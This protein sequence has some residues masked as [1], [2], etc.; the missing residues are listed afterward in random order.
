MANATTRQGGIRFKKSSSDP[1]LRFQLRRLVG[2]FPTE[3]GLITAEM[4]VAGR[5]LI[6]WSPEIERLNDSSGRQVEVF[7][8]QFGDFVL[9]DFSGSERI[10]AHGDRI[11]NADGVCQLNLD[12]LGKTRRYDI[13]RDVTGHIARRPV[14]FRRIL[15]GKCTAAM[16]AHSTIAVNNDFSSRQAAVALGAADDKPSGRIDVIF[17]LG[18]E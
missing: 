6:N 16:A 14:D 8:N 1:R 12:P 2:P 10:D 13:F 3:F 7:A 5:L 17:R 11:G 15:A 9:V 18:I 4:A